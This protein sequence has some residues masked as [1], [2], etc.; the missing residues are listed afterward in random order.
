MD[1]PDPPSH[2]HIYLLIQKIYLPIQQSQQQKQQQINVSPASEPKKP[3]ARS[4]RILT[5]EGCKFLR[6][7]LNFA[8]GEDTH[9]LIHKKHVDI[10][11]RG[12]QQPTLEERKKLLLQIRVSSDENHI[13][14]YSPTHRLCSLFPN[15][16]STR[17]PSLLLGLFPTD[18]ATAKRK[19][20]RPNTCLRLRP[21]PHQVRASVPDDK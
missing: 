5:R 13:L 6:G 19:R 3:R 18:G 12:L 21:R 10:F 4:S 1:P 14:I 7:E 16:K 8:C 2:S 15:V 20:L 17:C 9:I 11:N